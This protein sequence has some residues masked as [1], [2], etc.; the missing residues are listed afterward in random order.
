MI[1]QYVYRKIKYRKYK[2]ICQYCGYPLDNFEWVMHKGKYEN[3]PVHIYCKE[4]IDYED[5]MKL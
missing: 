4:Q 2:G 5:N 1:I 3:Y